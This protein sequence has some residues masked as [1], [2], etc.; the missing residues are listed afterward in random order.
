M[1]GEVTFQSTLHRAAY[2][3]MDTPQ[4]AYALLE[5]IPTAPPQQEQAVN[6]CLVLDR[7]GSMAGEK[8]RQMKEAAG[9]VV[10]RLG[11]GDTLA[12]VVFDDTA[13]VI[14]PCAPVLDRTA[15]RT[16]IDAIQERG[17]THMSSGMGAGLRELQRGQA[18]DRVSRMLLLTDGQ[19]WEDVEAC[20]SLADQCRQAG[21]SLNALGLGVGDE[22]N[23]DP[24]LLEELAVRSGGEWTVVD[25]PDKVTAVFASTL[26]AVQGVSLSKVALT[27]R[28]V[29]G[30]TP[31]AVWRV[32]PLISRLGQSAVG[33]WDV[34]VFL[35]DIQSGG[36]Q[37]I[38]VDLLLPPRKAGSY[39]LLQADI[40][41]D[42]PASGL[43]RQ[44][45]ALDIVVP[46]TQDPALAGQTQGRVMNI[47][48][49][50]VAHKLQTQALDE[51]AAGDIPRATMRL[52]AAATRLLELG[53]DQ[54]AEQANQQAE[55]LEQ[56][57]QIDTADMQRMRY[58]T[59]RLTETELAQAAE[60]TPPAF[61]E[62]SLPAA[63]EA[64][65]DQEALPAEEASTPEDAA[66]VEG[67]TT[68]P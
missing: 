44:R 18:P 41:Y 21:I 14:Y 12:V 52:R 65:S 11:S 57:G 63:E 37:A 60:S 23:W 51:A 2:L 58:A 10:D 62:P 48:E 15:I 38:L 24:R 29:E 34:Q 53:E 43:A 4:Q 55:H 45:A 35:G 17:G 13:D 47:I 8:L 39:R 7:S 36:G 5:I 30:V 54:M 19:T 25:H 31:R 9:L 6:F 64:A 33:G 26:Q 27:M 40:A 1:A 46:F 50:V 49:R 32:T 67:E 66:R 22:S 56:S 20:Q 59:R 3:S 16:W 68:E 61:E 42:L 28:M